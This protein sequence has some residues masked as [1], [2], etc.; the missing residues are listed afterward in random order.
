MT[1]IHPSDT[2]DRGVH[3]H[4]HARAHTRARERSICGLPSDPSDAAWGAA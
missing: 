2:S 1:Q 3:F 4:R